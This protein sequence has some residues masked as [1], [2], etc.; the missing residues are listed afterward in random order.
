MPPLR[1]AAEH[2]PRVKMGEQTLSDVIT[3]RLDDVV[4]IGEK[5][6]DLYH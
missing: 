4:S 6:E 3:D 1:E 5:H 2:E